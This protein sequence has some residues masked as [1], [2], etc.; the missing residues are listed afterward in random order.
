[1]TERTPHVGPFHDLEKNLRKAVTSADPAAIADCVR[2]SDV[3]TQEPGT[4]NNVAR[5][6]WNVIIEAPPEFADLIL[7]SPV[8][9]V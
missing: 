2:Y 3:L 6:L 8:L 9:P 4:S 5:I 1:M 7:S